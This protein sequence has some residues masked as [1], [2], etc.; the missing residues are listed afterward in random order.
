MKKI[1]G[2]SVLAVFISTAPLQAQYKVEFND[3]L[4][5]NVK[6]KEGANS[7]PVSTFKGTLKFVK[8]GDKYSNMI[9]TNSKGKLN[10]LFVA[11]TGS[12]GTVQPACKGSTQACF[13]TAD[14]S[15]TVYF[16]EP[17]TTTT[18]Q[19]RQTSIVVDL[20]DENPDAT[21]RRY[22]TELKISY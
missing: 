18:T 8:K 13:G 21:P 4:I 17:A 16:C 19:T 5:T 1:L 6:I 11:Q 2:L 14:N 20:L 10:K 7:I 22:R 3:I 15:I 12:N 9:F